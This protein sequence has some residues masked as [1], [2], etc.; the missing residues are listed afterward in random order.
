MKPFYNFSDRDRTAQIVFRSVSVFFMSLFLNT[1][2]VLESI[3]RLQPCVLFTVWTHWNHFDVSNSIY[4]HTIHIVMLYS[5]LN[6][7]LATVTYFDKKW[8][9]WTWSALS[10]C[11]SLIPIF[12]FIYAPNICLRKQSTK[13]DHWPS[14][15]HR[16]FRLSVCML[17]G[18]A[19]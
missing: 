6:N 17:N 15:F 1:V 16:T 12:N 9:C 11:E 10:W 2:H 13:S 18:C 5:L 3:S 19:H 7:T 14:F 4:Y 8:Q